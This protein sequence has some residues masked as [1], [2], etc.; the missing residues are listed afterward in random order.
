MRGGA[1]IWCGARIPPVG[2]P[3]LLGP[4]GP[5]GGPR[6]LARMATATRSWAPPG[7][8]DLDRTLRVL[9]RGPGDPAFR[10]A[11]DG[12]LWRASRTPA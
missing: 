1:R 8:Y 6:T 7:P 11:P 9:A 5:G 2:D 3:L 10:A 4:V 12:S